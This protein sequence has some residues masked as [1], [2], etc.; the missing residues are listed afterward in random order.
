M[1]DLL[2][3]PDGAEGK[4][5]Q[6]YRLLFQPMFNGVMDENLE[7]YVLPFLFYNGKFLYS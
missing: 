7:S 1:I 2:T 4:N 5:E 3:V 6:Q